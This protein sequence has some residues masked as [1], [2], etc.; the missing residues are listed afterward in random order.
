MKRIITSII[1]LISLPR[2]SPKAF[3]LIFFFLIM[4]SII[5][6]A[7]LRYNSIRNNTPMYKAV[8]SWGPNP[9]LP[10]LTKEQAL[11][12]GGKGHSDIAH[13]QNSY[14]LFPKQKSPNAVRIGIFGDSFIEGD[15][16]APGHEVP[17]ML[18]KKFDRAGLKNVEVINFG[19]GGRGVSHM[20]LLWD[21]IGKDYGLDYVILFPFDFHKL[22]DESFC[23]FCSHEGVYARFIIQDGGFK[24]IP[25]VGNS[26][27]EAIET[28]HSFFTPWPY[29]RYDNKMP[30]FLKVFLPGRFHGWTNPFYY[31]IRKFHRGEILDIYQMLFH[32]MAQ[33]NNLVIVANDAEIYSLD[34]KMKGDKV[35]FLKSQVQF[36]NSLY[37]APKFHNSALGTDLRA[38]ELF[39]WLIGLKAPSLKT[40]EFLPGRVN[41]TGVKD[42]EPMPVYT[43]QEVYASLG[44][45]PI[46]DFVTGLDGHYYGGLGKKFNF[47]KHKTVS[48]LSIDLLYDPLSAIHMRFLPLNFFLHENDPIILTFKLNSTLVT[49]PIGVVEGTSGV[50]GRLKMEK[51][52]ELIKNGTNW[53]LR[54]HKGYMILEGKGSIDDLKFMLNDREIL[55]PS[56]PLEANIVEGKTTIQINTWDFSPLQREWIYL[57]GSPGNYMDVENVGVKDGNLDLIL[58]TEDGQDYHYPILPYTISRMKTMEFA[59]PNIPSLIPHPKKLYQ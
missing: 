42:R 7:I 44:S 24:L 29:I 4:A 41:D 51:S 5:L 34:E 40:V 53:S 45:F 39:S 21:F 8:Q 17:T 46:A 48:L 33:V 57:R 27:R 50:I 9:P 1:E 30:M 31:K 20:Y 55:K 19:L 47:R 35:R 2:I 36:V 3:S 15:E 12:F 23:N 16:V 56:S 52:D 32:D 18:Q 49:V 54:I 43:Y 38:A 10:L 58:K 59:Q 6:F 25:I 28:Y 13:P 26:W 37:Y 11:Q 14:I 22:R